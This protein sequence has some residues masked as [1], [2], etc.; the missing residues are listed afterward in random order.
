MWLTYIADD[1]WIQT[2]SEPLTVETAKQGNKAPMLK[3]MLDGLSTRTE[4]PLRFT[5]RQL[6]VLIHQAN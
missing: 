5:V 1:G 6:Q 4:P 2:L 3:E